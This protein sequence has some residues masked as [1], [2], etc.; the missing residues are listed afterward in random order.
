MRPRGIGRGFSGESQQ[1][2]C[3]P[4]WPPD[5]YHG[6]G[7]RAGHVSGSLL[8][9]GDEQAA[10]RRAGDDHAGQ[11]RPGR[12]AQRGGHCHRGP[13][14]AAERRRP[15]RRRPAGWPAQ[16]QGHRL[17]Q[18]RAAEP[19]AHLHG[20]G[21]RGRR[22]EQEGRRDQLV[23]GAEAAQDVQRHDHRGLQAELR[24]RHADRLDVQPPDHA[25][26]RRRAV[27]Q[28]AHLQAGR[29]RLVLGRQRDGGVPAP[30]L[31]ARAH[32]GELRRELHRR[33]GRQGRLRRPQPAPEVLHRI[34]ADRGGQHELALYAGV[35]PEEAVR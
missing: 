6:G 9:T 5:G 23:P 20:D 27:P 26:G 7:G 21:H 35:L 28:P 19:V 3:G 10:A 2:R 4:V 14:Q 32:H 34:L 18:R 13:R 24:R 12:P 1:C 31:L 22:R 11:R 17:A 30:R 16:P 15:G 8:G 33:G 25:P 29:G